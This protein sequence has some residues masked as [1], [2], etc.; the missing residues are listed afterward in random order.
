MRMNF[1]SK[2]HIKTSCYW[3]CSLHFQPLIIAFFENVSSTLNVMCM[4][5]IYTQPHRPFCAA[6]VYKSWKTTQPS[7]KNHTRAGFILIAWRS[8]SSSNGNS[9]INQLSSAGFCSSSSERCTRRRRKWSWVCT[10]CG[11]DTFS[12]SC[13]I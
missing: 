12:P 11:C 1:S 13:V 10:L 8:G 9:E 6:C 5:Y 2:E 7:S 4:Y 3:M